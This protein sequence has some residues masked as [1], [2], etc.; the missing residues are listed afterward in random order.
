MVEEEEELDIDGGGESE[1]VFEEFLEAMVAFCCYRN[2]NPYVSLAKR[3]DQFLTTVLDFCL[4]VI[5]T[6]N[7]SVAP[8][9]ASVIILLQFLVL[10]AIASDDFSECSFHQEGKTHERV[11][12]F[13]KGPSHVSFT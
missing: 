4:R 10:F 6:L 3:L 13:T 12:F 2:C 9:H 5:C 11:C 1:M 8:H 7:L